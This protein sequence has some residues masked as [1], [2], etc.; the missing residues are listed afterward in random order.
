MIVRFEVDACLPQAGNGSTDIDE[1]IDQLT[2]G[3]TSVQLSQ[4]KPPPR[5]TDDA[6]K[7]PGLPR[8]DVLRAGRVVPQDDLI[9]MT[10]CVRHRYPIFDWAEAY[11]QLFLSGTP[12]HY[13]ALRDQGSF[14][15]IQKRTL[16]SDEMQ[17]RE[18]EMQVRFKRLRAVLQEIQE[19]VVRRGRSERRLCLVCRED[20]L[21]VFEMDTVGD[22]IPREMLSRFER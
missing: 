22:C 6:P 9:E 10:T 21:E 4:S 20:V 8:L 13:L 1:H 3:L 7:A 16:G 15:T 18:A 5:P 14:W 17:E 2:S 11:P 12:H 19:L